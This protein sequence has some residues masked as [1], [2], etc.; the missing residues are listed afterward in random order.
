MER[1]L[2]KSAIAQRIAERCHEANTLLA[3]FFASNRS[4]PRRMDAN[5]IIPTIAYQIARAIPEARTRITEEITRDPLLFAQSFEAQMVALVVRPLQP[6]VMAGFF[7]DPTSSRRIVIIDG[8]DEISDHGAQVKIIQVIYNALC[9]HKIP[10]IFL[11]ASRPEPEISHKFSLEPLSTMTG[12]L[13]LDNTFQ[14]WDDIQVFL[15]DSFLQIQK[16]HPLRKHPPF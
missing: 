12:R 5:Y 9:F 13:L 16:N 4:D 15:N 11:I 10:L 7:A 2:G 3:S 8:L 6:L 14:P 1:E